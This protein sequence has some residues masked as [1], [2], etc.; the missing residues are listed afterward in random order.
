[1]FQRE[2][3]NSRW[4]FSKHVCKYVNKHDIYA[5]DDS[6]FEGGGTTVH[7]ITIIVENLTQNTLLIISTL[8]SA[9]FEYVYVEYASFVGLI[10]NL[11]QM[12]RLITD[13]NHLRT[14]GSHSFQG[15]QR[16]DQSP[17]TEHKEG[18]KKNWLLINRGEARVNKNITEPF[19]G[20]GKFKCILPP[21][22]KGW[23][24]EVLLLISKGS[25]R[26]PFSY[27]LTFKLPPF[28]EAPG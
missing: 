12:I 19:G 23:P 9:W 2:I 15:E 26:K 11:T 8:L 10:L 14:T 20:L 16:V 27:N 1:M 25:L 5:V 21:S 24:L 22:H 28:T 7:T 17:P 6:F 3:L 13:K 4:S 18:K